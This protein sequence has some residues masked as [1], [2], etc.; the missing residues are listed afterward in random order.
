MGS[1]RSLYVETLI[2]A[3]ADELWRLT[4]EPD[5]HQRWDLRFTRIEYLPRSGDDD[6]QRFRYSVKLLPGLWITGTGICAGE[7]IRSDGT[8]TS[9][10]RFSS[11]HRL[12][13]IR[14]GTGYW[15]YVPADAGTRFLT[16]YDYEPRWDG[17]GELAD[18]LFRPAMGWA[19]AWSFDRLRLWLEDGILPEQSLRRWVMNAGL[20]TVVCAAAWLLTPK[21][22]APLLMLAVIGLPAPRSVPSARRCLRRPPDRLSGTYPAD[23]PPLEPPGPPGP[24]GPPARHLQGQS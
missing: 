13:L 1:R 10:L 5:Q 14:S 19:T 2:R 23:P 8:R 12:S 4:Q 6:R 9:V 20:R 18:R 7:R 11:G 16:G 24:P 3:D 15:R 17:F 22:F 21:L